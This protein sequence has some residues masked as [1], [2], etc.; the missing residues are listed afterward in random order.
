MQ[1]LHIN[2]LRNTVENELINPDIKEEVI[3]LLKSRKRWKL[4]SNVTETTGQVIIVVSTILAFASG[5]Y[6]DNNVL[7]FAAG[8]TGT[9]SLALLNFSKYALSESNERTNTLNSLLTHINITPVP[10]MGLT[11]NSPETY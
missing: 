5:V 8:C 2:D 7:S 1:Y 3:C 6:K 11:P 4:V 9:T 10:P